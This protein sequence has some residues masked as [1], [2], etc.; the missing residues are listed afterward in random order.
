MDSFMVDITNIKNIQIGTDIFIW[1]NV[2]ITIENVAKNCNTINYEILSNLAPRVV[3][4][5]I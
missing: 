4:E 2:N 1:D 3:K 5:F